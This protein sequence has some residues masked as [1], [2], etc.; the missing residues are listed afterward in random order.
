MEFALFLFR[1]NSVLIRNSALFE[2]QRNSIL[3]STNSWLQ[4]KSCPATAMQG[5]D[6]G[7]T[8]L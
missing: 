5:D 2:L 8:H 4:Q 6:G 3:C 7:S 1:F